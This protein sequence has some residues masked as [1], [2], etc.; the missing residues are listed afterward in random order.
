MATGTWTSFP[1]KYQ[2]PDETNGIFAYDDSRQRIYY[3]SQLSS[4][5]GNGTEY[6]YYWD[7]AQK[8][9]MGPY[10]NPGAEGPRSISNSGIC[11]DKANMTVYL[12]G[13]GWTE[14]Q[15]P[16]R[17]YDYNEFWEIDL[18]TYEW[19]RLMDNAGPQ[20]RQ[21][22]PMVFNP[23]DGLI[24]IYGGYHHTTTSGSDE[25]IRDD[26]YK[27]DPRLKFFQ[28]ISLTGTNPGGR[29][30]AAMLLI[31]EENILYFFGGVE[32]TQPSPTDQ[33]DL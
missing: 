2:S 4:Y 27:F 17:Y 19:T 16:T 18:N 32:N 13:G 29:K 8:D 25:E 11:F 1:L 12:Y 14:G 33:R 23:N 15:N 24:Y 5:W 7:I 20:K 10:Y 30:G 22:F 21:G 31:E 26:F 3:V 6:I 9:W 28:P